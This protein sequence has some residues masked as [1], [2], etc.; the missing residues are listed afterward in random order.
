MGYPRQAPRSGPQPLSRA[1]SELIALRGYARTQGDAQLQAAW[2]QVAGADFAA[3]TRAVGIR[4]GVLHVSVS[5]A[6]LLSQLA[7]FH[8]VELLDRL[9]LRHAHLRIRDLKFKLDSDVGSRRS[10]RPQPET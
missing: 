9:R 7:G 3:S 8:K 4:R 6:P 5:S 2:A 1:V 10:S